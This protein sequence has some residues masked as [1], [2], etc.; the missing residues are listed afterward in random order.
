MCL[1]KSWDRIAEAQIN[2]LLKDYCDAIVFLDKGQI[3]KDIIF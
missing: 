1:L 3:S 2:V